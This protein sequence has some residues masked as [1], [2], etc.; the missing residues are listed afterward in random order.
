MCRNN[1]SIF[2]FSSFSGSK[3][4]LIGVLGRL[5]FEI[6]NNFQK[7][8]KNPKKKKLR[9]NGHFYAKPVFDQ[10]DFFVLNSITNHFKYLKYSPNIKVIV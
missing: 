9:K 1:A 3:V 8:R 6:P 2:N 4:N 10:I 7:H 5:F